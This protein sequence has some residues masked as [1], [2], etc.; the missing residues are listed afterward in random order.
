MNTKVKS[1]HPVRRNR[2]RIDPSIIVALIS[3]A[4]AIICSLLS[5]FKK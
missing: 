3:A 1:D 4:A 2:R 5:L